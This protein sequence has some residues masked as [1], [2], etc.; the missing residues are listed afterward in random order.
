MT[1][2]SMLSVLTIKVVLLVSVNHALQETDR[3][4]FVE[5]SNIFS[6]LNYFL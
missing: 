2:F 4:I 5:V 6:I 3:P 1:A